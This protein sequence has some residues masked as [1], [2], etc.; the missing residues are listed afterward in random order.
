MSYYG[1]ILALLCHYYVT[2]MS[3]FRSDLV[4]SSVLW[5][6][7]YGTIIPNSSRIMP[8]CC[9]YNGPNALVLWHYHGVIMALLCFHIAL[10]WH[11]HGSIMAVL[12]RNHGSMLSLC[13]F[14]PTLTIRLK[15]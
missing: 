3:L 6:Y 9:Y 4:K 1:T 13:T 5:M 2:I 11:P 7:N 8:L 12:W 10:S 15:M 14:E